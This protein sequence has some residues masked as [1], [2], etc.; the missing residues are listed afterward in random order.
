[1]L[2]GA[3]RFNI[4]DDAL[5]PIFK[6]FQLN[7]IAHLDFVAADYEPVGSLFRFVYHGNEKVMGY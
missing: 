4:G 1:M 7:L 5:N 6:A 3:D 2:A